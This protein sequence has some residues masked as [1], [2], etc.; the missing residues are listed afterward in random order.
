MNSFVKGREN[1]MNYKNLYYK[2]INSYLGVLKDASNKF[3]QIFHDKNLF[4]Y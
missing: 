2:E 3:E 1:K 4:I